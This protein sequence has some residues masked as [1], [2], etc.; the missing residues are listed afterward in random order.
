ML[1]IKGS[2]LNEWKLNGMKTVS[3]KEKNRQVIFV[4]SF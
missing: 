1:Q 4:F 3:Q 2:E